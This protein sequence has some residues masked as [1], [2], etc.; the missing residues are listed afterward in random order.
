MMR[1]FSEALSAKVSVAIEKNASIKSFE[2]VHWG[3]FSTFCLNIKRFCPR[4]C[5]CLCF[6]EST[7]ER[8]FTRGFEKFFN[9]IEITTLI[10]TLRILKSNTKR[11]FSKISWRLYKL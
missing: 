3:I 11:N 8:M 7:R 6:R 9:E 1:L 4:R 10:R 2:S 5:K